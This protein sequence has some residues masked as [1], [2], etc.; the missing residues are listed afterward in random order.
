MKT[1]KILVFVVGALLLQF[2]LATPS[3]ALR[4]IFDTNFGPITLDWNQATGEISGTYPHQQGAVSGLRDANGVVRGNW[5]QRGNNSQ[6]QFVWNMNAQGF[7]ENWKYTQDTM[8]RGAWNGTFRN[9][10]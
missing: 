9:C 6:G 4:C 2:M 5:W 1:N 7:S 8:W 3:F 10:N